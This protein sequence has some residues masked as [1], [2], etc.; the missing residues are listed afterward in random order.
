MGD[1]IAD[2]YELKRLLGEG[3]MGAVYE[4]VHV[5]LGKRL[6]IKVIHPEFCESAEVVARFRREAR[7]ASAV[8]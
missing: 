2:K 6:A 4:G 7:A 3:S 8:E 5:D 1:R